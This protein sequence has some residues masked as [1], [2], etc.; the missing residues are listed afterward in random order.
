VPRGLLAAAAVTAAALIASSGSCGVLDA[1]RLR[2]DATARFE[3]GM[4][5]GLY[6]HAEPSHTFRALDEIRS[7]G[8]NSIAIMIPWVTA[9]IHS[10][11]IAPHPQITPSDRS[12]RRAIRTAHDLGMRVLLMP[13]VY[14]A[15]LGEGEWRG[16]LAPPD[17][18]AWFEQYGDFILHYAALSEEEG[19]HFFSVGSELCST[20]SRRRD[21]ERLIGSVRGVFT[22]KV[23][24][25]A[26]WDHRDGLE[27]AGSLDLLGMNAYFELGEPDAPV[28]VLVAAWG[29]ILEEVEAWRSRFGKDLI[30]TEVGYPSRAGAVGDPWNHGATGDAAPQE[31]FRLYEAFRRAWGGNPHLQGVYFYQWWGAGGPL[32]TGYTPRGKPAETVVREW[33]A[34]P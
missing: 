28:E 10:A 21:W 20:E 3:K 13:F 4:V 26:N 5:F 1:P 33:Y 27:F 8:T 24:Y 17:W 31:Q 11:D 29:P 2:G 14:V 7:L 16:T 23:T 19:V 25:S 22:G 30:L 34:G 32:D 18:E 15:E 6:S 9:D 12:L